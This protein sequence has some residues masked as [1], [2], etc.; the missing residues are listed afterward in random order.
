MCDSQC[1]LLQRLNAWSLS[2]YSLLSGSLRNNGNGT[3]S[4]H[5]SR[6]NNDDSTHP[7]KVSHLSASGLELYHRVLSGLLSWLSPSPDKLALLTANRFRVWKHP[8]VP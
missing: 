5:F 4:S 2:R 3:F 6:T 1:D 8:H 7:S